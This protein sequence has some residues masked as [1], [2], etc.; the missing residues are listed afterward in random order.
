MRNSRKA[1]KMDRDSGKDKFDLDVV[2]VTRERYLQLIKCVK[3][4]CASSLKPKN[5]IIIDSSDSYSNQIIKEISVLFKKDGIKLK[6]Y[7]IHHRGVG[8][9]R[10]FGLLKV[11]SPYFAF[12]DDDEFV[13]KF[14][15]E[16]IFKLISL[17]KDIHVLAGPKIPDDNRNY[18]HRVWKSLLADEFNY[19]GFI[20]TV[21][22][23]NSVYL[24][25][26]VRRHNLKFDVRFEQ[27]SEDQAFSYELRKINAKMFFHKSVW[28][29][30]NCRRNL[31]PFMK[32]WFYYGLN[33]HLY[34]KLYLGSGNISEL[35]KAGITLV[36]LK[37]T[38]PY[39]GK[40][41]NADI[42]P[43]LVMLNTAFLVGFL[44]SFLGF[45]TLKNRINTRD[46]KLKVNC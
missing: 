18:W 5:L 24:T 30:H 15:L 21:P 23:G 2:I 39:W 4:I 32:Q 38:F 3:H 12:V 27:C 42:Y 17:K 46:L 14:W 13:P 22:S 36:N 43:G 40:L 9:S 19:K 44:Y 28:I 37:K 45:G 1:R 16:R 7:K 26:F 10:N 35:H 11:K 33:K 20:D 25:S 29:K 41:Y 34:H 8:Y 31:T 6:Y